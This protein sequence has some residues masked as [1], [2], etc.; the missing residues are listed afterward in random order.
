MDEDNGEMREIRQC[1]RGSV[2]CMPLYESLAGQSWTRTA[3]LW[4]KIRN[5]SS[6]VQ[7]RIVVLGSCMTRNAVRCLITKISCQEASLHRVMATAPDA[8]S[9][10]NPTGRRATIHPAVSAAPAVHQSV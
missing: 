7:R 6:V 1:C 3:W 10:W 5:R 4:T 2:A 8:P 9:W